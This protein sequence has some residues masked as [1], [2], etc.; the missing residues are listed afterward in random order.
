MP[1]IRTQVRD[2]VV[3]RLRT[4]DAFACVAPFGRA[5]R[6][7][8]KNE[9]PAALVRV[10]ENLS[11]VGKIRP[12]VVRREL[13]VT[14]DLLASLTSG[15]VDTALDD[16]SIPIEVVLADPSA[17]GIG[18]LVEWRPVATA[19]G[20]FDLGEEVY[21]RLTIT[22]ACAVST[23]EGVPTANIHA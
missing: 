21:G 17:L 11:P 7:F 22:Y 5:A 8:Q 20:V 3:A 12:R 10:S 19:P 14:I 6:N 16:L 23:T 9:I 1:H 18:S 2:A 15:D 4:V 13:T